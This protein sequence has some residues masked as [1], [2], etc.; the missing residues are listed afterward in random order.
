MEEQELDSNGK[1]L[2]TT[3]KQRKQ[4]KMSEEQQIEGN[5]S[6]P[7]SCIRA[8][9]RNQLHRLGALYSN[10]QDLS[11]PVHRTE[12]A[13]SIEEDD[14]DNAENRSANKLRKLKRLA[15]LTNSINKWEDESTSKYRTNKND[16][17]ASTSNSYETAVSGKSSD[18][19]GVSGI[20]PIS[21][22]PGKL[23]KSPSKYSKSP[24][25][26]GSILSR[27][28]S[29]EKKETDDN[30]NSS[31]KQL[32]WD[33]SI[34]DSLESQGF[35]RRD[36]T[37]KRLEYNFSDQT[38][39]K[40]SNIKVSNV[41]KPPTGAVC[42]GAIPKSN[43]KPEPSVTKKTEV[44]KG[45]VFGRAAI[46]ETSAPRNATTASSSSAA[47]ASSSRNQKD[48]AE[49]SLRERMALF[50]K[51]K[52]TAL[53]PK[54]ALGMA[55]SAKQIMA[56][57][58]PS[59]NVKQVIT[60][61]QQPMISSHA[62]TSVAPLASKINNFNK[63]SK[64]ETCAA[65]SGIRQTV[66][67]LLSAPATIAESRIANDIRKIRQQEMNVVLN[68]F[69]QQS[70]EPAPPPPA[71]PMP[72]N[73]FKTNSGGRKRL[74]GK[75]ILFFGLFDFWGENVANKIGFSFTDEKMGVSPEVR[76]SLENIKRVKVNPPKNGHSLYPTL[77]DIESSG[78]DRGTPETYSPEPPYTDDDNEQHV[79]NR[80]MY[81]S[82]QNDDE[83][84]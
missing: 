75:S 20:K 44:S 61:P 4:I 76:K 43:A 32:K 35:K 27:I 10:P 73:L 6:A 49:M 58:K 47:A 56:D 81:N 15:E 70:E 37:N 24:G 54:A 12:T 53:I 45:L 48:P 34:M 60:T 5:D 72:E 28:E 11:S 66:A 19:K 16:N 41:T 25:K 33:K 64:A 51:N 22:S 30:K 57:K 74:S 36:T 31:N 40:E 71:P 65:G 8:S 46:F 1:V 79:M 83:D 68:R 80:Y 29:I 9:S 7:S 17:E 39:L 52:G 78:A 2:N 59:E 26:T 69:N 23:T 50:E 77:S 42:K 62:N 14:T 55:P 67:A 63:A 21:K 13:F 38:D 84:R 82:K 3:Q 18:A